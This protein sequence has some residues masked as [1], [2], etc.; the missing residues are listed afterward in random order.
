MVIHLGAL[1]T[2]QVKQPEIFQ[3]IT[4]LFV[5][6]HGRHLYSTICKNYSTE[7]ILFAIVVL[8]NFL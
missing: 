8:Y 1:G 6:G 5:I 4:L 2:A 3:Q 7:R